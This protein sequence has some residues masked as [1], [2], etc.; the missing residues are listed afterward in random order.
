LKSHREHCSADAHALNALGITVCQQVRVK[1]TPSNYALY[2]VSEVRHEDT[3]EIVR[4][5]QRGRLRLGTTE[6]T[7]EEF[8]AEFDSQVVNPTMSDEK[9]KQNGEFIERLRDDGAHTALIVIAPHGGRIEEHTDDQARG[10]ASCLADKAV[11]FW[12]CKGYHPQGAYDAWHIASVDIHP[13]SFP[14]LNSLF[15]RRFTDAVAFHG[16]KPDEEAETDVLVGGMASSDLKQQIASKIQE[17]A[18]ASISVRVACSDDRFNGDDPRNIV[19]RLTIGG[20]NGVQI[21]QSAL[22]REAPHSDKIAE[23]D[24]QVYRSRMP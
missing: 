4:M 2:T 7:D 8:D 1:R 24:A 9:A 5:G 3:E 22:A 14:L 16:V 15:S 19:N 13:E 6:E 11:S 18:G 20:A 12:V 17:V 10:V 21:E 23:A